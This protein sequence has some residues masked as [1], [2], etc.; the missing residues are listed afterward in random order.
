MAVGVKVQEAKA[1]KANPQ[2][3]KKA[4]Q[5]GKH[6]NKKVA[7]AFLAAVF[8]IAISTF[9][10]V[11]TASGARK[12]SRL[13]DFDRILYWKQGQRGTW[14]QNKALGNNAQVKYWQPIEQKYGLGYINSNGLIQRYWS[15][16]GVITAAQGPSYSGCLVDRNVKKKKYI[17]YI[18]HINGASYMGELYDVRE[19]YWSVQGNVSVMNRYNRKLGARG[20]DVA[21]SHPN[22]GCKD[23]YAGTDEDDPQTALAIE[24]HF[25]PHGTLEPLED[26]TYNPNVTNHISCNEGEWGCDTKHATTVPITPTPG[27][28]VVPGAPTTTTV[29]TWTMD[30]YA[31]RDKDGKVLYTGAYFNKDGSFYKSAKEYQEYL[32]SQEDLVQ[33]YGEKKGEFN[34][35]ISFYDIDT[36]HNERYVPV[37]GV[38]SVFTTYNSVEYAGKESLSGILK[39]N[40]YKE[41]CPNRTKNDICYWSWGGGSEG[42][43]DKLTYRLWFN[44]TSTSERP[45][46]LIY[47]GWAHASGFYA[48]NTTI[49]YVLTDDIND[50]PDEVI[51]EIESFAEEYKRFYGRELKDDPFFESDAGQGI[52]PEQVLRLFPIFSYS[53][54]DPYLI[55]EYLVNL[56][57]LKGLNWYNCSNTTLSCRIPHTEHKKENE[58][59]VT[60]TSIGPK[61]ETI[62]YINGYDFVGSATKVYYG[63]IYDT[64]P[65]NFDNTCYS[66][67]NKPVETEDYDR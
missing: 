38:N 41:S 24:F 25:Y 45:F 47:A 53:D 2:E 60:G 19:Y 36:R 52:D 63:S 12:V 66:D 4:S 1:K 61:G 30:A 42:T 13:T 3:A 22:D 56:Q 8:L 23:V 17:E 21:N 20:N 35:T 32:K 31:Y 59:K 46:A 64:E 9:V 48:N 62:E 67:D 37:S 6:L 16:K 11:M 55:N 57:D 49:A 28:P 43:P 50:M 7:F 5:N 26:L 54:Y 10:G 51:E 39:S 14:E 65:I 44:F 18:D 29:V 27:A 34:G 40:I 58:N 15:K 33:Q